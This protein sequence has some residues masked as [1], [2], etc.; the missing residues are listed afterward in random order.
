MT[1]RRLVAAAAFLVALVLAGCGS[2]AVTRHSTTQAARQLTQAAA[3][4]TNHCEPANGDGYMGVCNP[5]AGGPPTSSLRLSSALGFPQGVDVSNNNGSV[6]FSYLKRNGIA[7]VYAKAE[8]QCFTDSEL[9]HNAAGAASERVAFG[10]YDF[11]QP[12]R[13]APASDAACLAA[14]ERDVLARTHVTLPVVFDAESFNGLGGAQICVWLHAAENALRS[15]LP[16][17]TV[18]VY[19]SP[20]TMPGCFSNGTFA[21]VADWLVSSPVNLPGYTSRFNW[22][23]FGP[24]FASGKLEGMDRDKGSP[25]IFKLEYR[26]PRPKPTK[27]QRRAAKRRSLRKHE[28]DRRELHGDI[29]RHDC[30]PGQHVIPREP[31]STR[32]H[33]HNELCPRWLRKGG[34]DIEVIN[35]YHHEGIF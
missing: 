34:R 16:G 9:A 26:G 31:L 17:V 23:W 21:W 20:G 6:S 19:G 4:G 18:G 2:P 28:A 5:Q 8:Q 33:L 13:I 12:G 24:R 35:R 15:D 27:A 11:I 32:R 14:R 10:I 25:D 7:F 3:L 22:Q 29:D 30:R 1:S